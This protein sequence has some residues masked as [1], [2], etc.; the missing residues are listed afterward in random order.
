[1]PEDEKPQNYE[2]TPV[3]KILK[4]IKDGIIN[5]KKLDPEIRQGCVEHLWYTEARTVA[6]MAHIL[7]VSDK[8][9]LR[10]RDV[11]R[12]RNAKRSSTDYTVKVFGELL[13]KANCAHENMMRISRS[14]DAS[15]QEKAQAGYYAWKIIKE[16]IEIA[17]SLGVV[18]SQALRIEANIRQE[19]ET[20]PAQLKEELVRLVG[21]VE[22][23][24][25]ADSKVTELIETT[26]KQIAL[27]EAKAGIKELKAC[28][29]DI[30]KGQGTV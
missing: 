30:E 23:K 14:A 7:D 11:I 3:L 20:S 9:I 1:M 15:A 16:Q 27:A 4:Q 18:P 22:A 8:T 19:E 5:P 10:D 2:N 25:I 6:E 28:I 24:G 12:E 13:E 29:D 26:K 17:Q 21:I